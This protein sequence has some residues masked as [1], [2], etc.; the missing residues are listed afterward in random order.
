MVRDVEM[1][2]A[3]AM[4]REHDQDEQHAASERRHGEEIHRR[5]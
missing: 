3:P 5:G 4:M 1:H 2:D